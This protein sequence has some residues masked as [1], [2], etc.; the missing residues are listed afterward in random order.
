MLFSLTSLRFLL[1][2]VDMVVLIIFSYMETTPPLS[3][4]T[5]AA[6]DC[7]K[8]SSLPALSWARKKTYQVVIGEW[9]AQTLMRR[10]A[11][12]RAQTNIYLGRVL[13]RGR[14]KF[15]EFRSFHKQIGSSPNFPSIPQPDRI[16]SR[17]C[18]A[19]GDRFECKF[20][21]HA[22]VPLRLL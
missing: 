13:E 17:L 18:A 21:S 11:I 20:E 15:S 19:Y 2:P 12:I 8:S 1:W 9:Q 3:P 6:T 16:Y 4:P 14:D 10:A 7:K 22:F 5:S